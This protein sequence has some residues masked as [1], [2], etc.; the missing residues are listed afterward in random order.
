MVLGTIDR[1]PPPFFKQGVSALSK[2]VVFA[3]LS[4][5]CMVGDVRFRI[6]EPLRSA[7]SLLLTPFEFVIVWPKDT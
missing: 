7:I 6:S 1:T 4:V 5:L 2:L 3:L